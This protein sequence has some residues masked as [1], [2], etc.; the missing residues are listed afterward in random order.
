MMTITHKH[1][2]QWLFLLPFFLY[3]DLILSVG[4]FVIGYLIIEYEK[5]DVALSKL[6]WR[7]Y[8]FFIYMFHM[9][10]GEREFA[11][12][13]F[14]P[15]FVTE[16]VIFGLVVSYARELLQIRKV[17]L[18]YYLIVL[19][20]LGFAVVYFSD[21]QIDAIRDSFM[22]VYAIWVPIVYY[23]FKN[24]NHYDLFFL[25]LKLF[26]VLKGAQ[27]VYEAVMILTGMKIISFEG[28]RFG[29]G[30]ILP[31]LIV[32]T[33]FLPLRQVDVK[34]KIAALVMV[35]AVFTMFHRSVFLGIILGL[36]LIFV[37][38]SNFTRKKIVTYG[39][40]S[41]VLLI[42][43]LFYYNT[44]VDVDI[45]RILELKTSLEEGNINYRFVSWQH[46]MDKFY[47]HFLLGYGVGQP[48]MFSQN[49][50]FYNT[51]E[52]T[53]FQIRDLDGNAQ[54]HNSYLNILARFGILIFPFFLY[55]VLQPLKKIPEYMRIKKR[56]GSHAYSKFLLLIGFLIL[57]YV[58]AF[59]NVVLEGPH[60]AFPFWLAIGMLL[61]YGRAGNFSEKFV[62]IKQVSSVS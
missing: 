6:E 29:V 41:L 54:P 3:E 2:K 36:L 22:L 38:G 8:L 44:V 53:Y 16:I 48:V 20:G 10:F 37:I 27:Y 56:G 15:L 14:E 25:F 13:G 26:I 28:F 49:N 46:V 1:V 59:F 61:G 7:E 33:I 60:H 31:S 18:V 35:P 5:I 24:E 58:L 62:Q 17:L 4:M 30:F 55:A 19:A 57:M 45:F 43:F 23:I 47:E 9:L 32:L 11:Y 21:N 34:Y 12:V 40:L 42:G 52:L 51:V 50:I 39:L